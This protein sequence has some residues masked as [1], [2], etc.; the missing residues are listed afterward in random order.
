MAAMTL[1]GMNPAEVRQLAEQ[2]RR[3]SEQL[4]NIVSQVDGRIAHSSWA[5]RDSEIFKHQWWPAHRRALLLAAE[6]VSGLGQSARNNADEQERASA[7]STAAP[8]AQAMG[9]AVSGVAVGS[10]S[11]AR[12][13]T[14]AGADSG[15]SAGAVSWAREHV[16]EQARKDECLGF[17]SDA[18]S[19]KG[20]NYQALVDPAHLHGTDTYPA[21]IW[22]HFTGGITGPNTDLNPPPG[23]FVFYAGD[24]GYEREHS[25]VAISTGG[26][27]SIS[28]P[29]TRTDVADHDKIHLEPVASRGGRYLGWWLPV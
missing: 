3:G 13:A 20:V 14:P 2:L 27:Q 6:S 24:V 19:S 29:D 1:T 10:E 23:A 26:G 22:G 17:V 18:W 25:H 21:D 28:T 7:A 5:G 8:V 9:A 15:S 12:A 11:Q 4:R 16:G